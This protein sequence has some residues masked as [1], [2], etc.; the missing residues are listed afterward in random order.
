MSLT[1]LVYVSRS[2]D[3]DRLTVGKI[4]SAARKFN[5]PHD[6]SG[7][8]LFDGTVYLQ[9]LEGDR[10]ALSHLYYRIAGDPRH[11][12]VTLLAAGSLS[13]RE[14]PGWAMGY[15]DAGDA[16][17]DVV[18]RFSSSSTFDPYTMSS[19]SALALTRYVAKKRGAIRMTDSK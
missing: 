6:I 8:L 2:T 3:T 13:E 9:R 15:I 12:D 16:V 1:Q 10:E 14:C 5:G 11:T 19:D 17:K 7:L 18:R 4:L